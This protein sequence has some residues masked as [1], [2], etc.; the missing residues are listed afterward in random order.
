MAIISYSLSG[1]LSWLTGTSGM[2]EVTISMADGKQVTISGNID[3][4]R[5]ELDEI[6]KTISF[7]DIAKV[8]VQRNKTV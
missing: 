8:N 6:E 5:Q 4:V 1:V 7:E 2:I 3:R